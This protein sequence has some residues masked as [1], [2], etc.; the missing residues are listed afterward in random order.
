VVIIS[1]SLLPD[2]LKDRMA[3]L[4]NHPDLPSTVVLSDSADA[5]EHAGSW[6]PV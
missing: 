1:Q 2:P 4:Q 3:E 5:E 6:P